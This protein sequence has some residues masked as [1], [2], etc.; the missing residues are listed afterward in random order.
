VRPHRQHSNTPEGRVQSRGGLQAQIITSQG[1]T[2]ST[3]QVVGM[4]WVGRVVLPHMGFF[5]EGT[6]ISRVLHRYLQ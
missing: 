6:T 1:M 3:P 4:E 5:F 2:K